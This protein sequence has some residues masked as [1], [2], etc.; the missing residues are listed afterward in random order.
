MSR[1]SSQPSYIA[2][3]DMYLVHTVM[4]S[5][6]TYTCQF[7]P[8]TLWLSACCRASISPPFLIKPDPLSWHYL[9]PFYH[10]PYPIQTWPVI[11][12]RIFFP[13]MGVTMLKIGAL[14]RMRTLCPAATLRKPLL[15]YIIG[16]RLAGVWKWGLGQMH[17]NSLSWIALL[18]NLQKKL[19]QGCCWDAWF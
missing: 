14:W 11:H 17:T 4:L 18:L 7:S 5:L 6:G 12:K 19:Q 8:L 9:Q 15:S 2:H 10:Q 3:T 1:T 13:M 16:P